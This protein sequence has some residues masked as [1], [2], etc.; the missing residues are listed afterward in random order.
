MADTTPGPD[1]DNAR[2]V[3]ALHVFALEHH[4]FVDDL[5][6]LVS[7]HV[8]WGL[9]VRTDSELA[10]LVQRARA[11]RLLSFPNVEP[12]VRRLVSLAAREEGEPHGARRS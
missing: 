11:L 9:I 5:L 4:R 3:H 1:A 7:R 6:E 10:E 2:Q 8:A 12:A